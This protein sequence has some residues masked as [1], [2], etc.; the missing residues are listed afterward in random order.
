MTHRTALFASIMLVASLPCGAQPPVAPAAPAATP[1]VPATSP[2]APASPVAAPSATAT[3]GANSDSAAPGSKPA[4]S[5]TDAAAEPSPEV[6]KMARHEGFKP[7]K[8]HDGVT[9][10][11]STGAA[12]GTHFVSET[13][14]D[15]GELRTLARQREDQRNL[16]RQP[17]ACVGGCSGH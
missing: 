13:C 12:I 4:S 1:A 17:G 15:E 16:L 7:K 9:K 3:P 5:A 11:C 10:F 14:V 6:L 2:A 8:G